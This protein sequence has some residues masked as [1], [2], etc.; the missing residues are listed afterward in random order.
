M[1]FNNACGGEKT[2][3]FVAGCRAQ[4]T[5]LFAGRCPHCGQELEFFTI[6]EIRNQRYCY[7]CK[8]K[9][10]PGKFA[11]DIGLSI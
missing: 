5:Q 7:H 8:G 1:S 10:D 6:T 9:F 3:G 4:K 11:A 2:G